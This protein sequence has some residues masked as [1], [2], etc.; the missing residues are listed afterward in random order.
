MHHNCIG[1]S[2]RKPAFKCCL[3]VVVN[4]NKPESLKVLTTETVMVKDELTGNRS[5][6]IILHVAH[7]ISQLSMLYNHT[8]PNFC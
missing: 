3:M 8:S 4:A 6:I 2:N 5:A 1:K 7:I